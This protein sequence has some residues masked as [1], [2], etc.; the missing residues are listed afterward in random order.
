LEPPGKP[1]RFS[2]A[3]L[4]DPEVAYQQLIGILGKPMIHVSRLGD[5]LDQVPLGVQAGI[6]SL[7]QQRAP[8]NAAL[9]C[10]HVSAQPFERDDWA[11][12]IHSP[13]LSLFDVQHFQFYAREELAV[14]PLTG[15]FNAE[16]TD[17]RPID[18]AKLTAHPLDNAS[19]LYILPKHFPVM[20]LTPLQRHAQQ[21]TQRLKVFG[22]FRLATEAG[23]SSEMVLPQP[24]PKTWSPYQPAFAQPPALN[25]QADAAP[26]WQIETMEF[27][28]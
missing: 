14:L 11:V 8:V 25:A 4:R 1:G 26:Y 21:V 3:H 28:V 5:W 7:N 2:F 16:R 24:S 18:E 23:Q 9:E 15:A 22:Q 13:L 19:V 6:G 27:K 17:R 12:R 20:K 10:R